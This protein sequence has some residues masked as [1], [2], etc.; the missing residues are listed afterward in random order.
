M[1]LNILLVLL[2]DCFCITLSDRFSGISFA[3]PGLQDCFV[4]TPGAQ[5]SLIGG[6]TQYSTTRYFSLISDPPPDFLLCGSAIFS[7][8][9][10]FFGVPL[11]LLQLGCI[12]RCQ[13]NPII[14]GKPTTLA[15][16]LYL[17]FKGVRGINSSTIETFISDDSVI[18]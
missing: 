9:W 2:C 6:S 1:P 10:N 12:F 4:I 16:L 11:T 14:S 15:Y 5:L 7:L 18:D 3:F 13:P 8:E 17:L